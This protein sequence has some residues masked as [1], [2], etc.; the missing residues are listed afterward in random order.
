MLILCCAQI[1]QSVNRAR[2]STNDAVARSV[3][4]FDPTHSTVGTR[5]SF[6]EAAFDRSLA[7]SLARSRGPLRPGL[8]AKAWSDC[9]VIAGSVWVCA[10][11][12]GCA[13]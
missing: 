3:T 2:T 4:M 7:R 9:D 5:L 8:R 12:A 6:S 11:L 1:K 13:V 10:C